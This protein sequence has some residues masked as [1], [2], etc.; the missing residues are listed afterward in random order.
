LIAAFTLISL[1]PLLVSGTISYV[2]SSRAIEQK[3]RLFATEIV[4]Q[5]SKNV[6]L[7]MAEIEAASEAL[8]LSDPVQSALAHYALDNPAEKGR[9]RADLTKILLDTYGSFEDIGQ[10]YFLDAGNRILDPQVF[11]RPGRGVAQF[12][13][14]AAPRKGRTSWGTLDLW[15]GQK[16]IVMLRQIYF[17]SDNRLAGSLFLGLRPV[18]FSSIF[19]DVHLGD[20]SDIFIL[21]ARDGSGIVQTRDR[22]GGGAAAPALVAHIAASLAHGRQTGC[23]LYEDA[24]LDGRAHAT[25]LAAYTQIPR[26]TWYVVSTLPNDALLAEAQ[27]VRDK[28]VLIGVLCF[29]CAIGLAYAI[30]RSISAPLEKLAGIMRETETGNYA[31]RMEYEGRDELALLAQKF[32]E[33]AGNIG[34]AHDQLES[35]VAERTRDL[36]Q[37]NQKLAALSMT[38]S[39]TGIANRR[40]FDAVLEAEL[41]RAA[42]AVQPVALLMIDVDYFKKYND[43]Y[44]HQEGDAC[45]RKVASLLQVHA[46]RAGDLA[47]R[48]G[49]EEFVLLAADTGADTAAALAEDVRR[50]LEVLCLTHENSPTGCVTISVGVAVLVPD[51]RQTPEMFIRMADKAM[52]RAKE[53]G[54]NQVVLAG[55]K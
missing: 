2:E 39:L 8:V 6:Q 27:S 5:V 46:R 14:A 7:Q 26:T 1:L 13:A 34:Q 38:D 53:Q 50:A 45:L 21:D 22:P 12:A 4:K 52:Y 40:R 15:S 51:E 35:R 32:N 47:A 49:G 42:R 36:E 43:F 16:S 3:T 24:A 18:R 29:L 25:F 33:M 17:K 11:T 28:I 41:H 37:A 55:R 23:L 19:D 48:Y 10:K 20:G 31:L 44:G 30:A 9:A 54:R